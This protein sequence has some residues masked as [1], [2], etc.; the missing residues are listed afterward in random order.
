VLGVAARHADREVVK[1]ALEAGGAHPAEVSVLAA[2]LLTHPSWD[3]RAAAARALGT[4]GDAQLGAVLHHALAHEADGLV[5][6][7]L[8][9]ALARLGQR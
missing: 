2:G 5:R 8:T 1:C 4:H 6:E 7:A 3:V 9:E